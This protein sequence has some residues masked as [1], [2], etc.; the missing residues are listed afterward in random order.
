MFLVIGLTQH[1]DN[2]ATLIWRD[3]NLLIRCATNKVEV[4]IELNQEVAAH[5]AQFRN[6]GRCGC[7]RIKR[8]EQITD[9]GAHKAF[10]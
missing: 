3:L 1:M 4:L 9:Q 8:T 5:A 2:V 10:A 6:N 7:N